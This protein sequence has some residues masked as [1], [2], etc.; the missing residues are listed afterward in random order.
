MKP[1]KI[2]DKLEQLSKN[3]Y[4]CFYNGNIEAFN[5]E[6]NKFYDS[7]IMND[8][9][10]QSVRVAYR[11]LFTPLT[12]NHHYIGYQA[13]K[14]LGDYEN[15][16]KDAFINPNASILS[17]EYDKFNYLPHLISIQDFIAKKWLRYIWNGIVWKWWYPLYARY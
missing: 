4:E 15:R 8:K 2:Y 1:E 6:I 11:V 7:G 13:D 5:S 12:L 10:F 9:N 3:V 16:R 17:I 14:D